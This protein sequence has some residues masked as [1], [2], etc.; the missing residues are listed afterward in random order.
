MF[1]A[2]QADMFCSLEAGEP[3]RIIDAFVT[4]ILI[5]EQPKLKVSLHIPDNPCFF[6]ST[7]SGFVLKGVITGCNIHCFCLTYNQAPSYVF[8]RL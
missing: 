2:S 4:I 3:R 8:H 5:H 6:S 1:I 7:I